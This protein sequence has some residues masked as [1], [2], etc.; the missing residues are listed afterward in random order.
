MANEYKL[1]LLL[2]DGTEVD[3]GVIVVPEGEK[4]DKGDTGATGPTGAHGKDGKSAYQYALEGGYSGTEQHFAAKLA[5][6][7][8]TPQMYGAVADGITDDTA[9]VQAALNAGG[10]IYFPAGRYKV[11]SQ[12]T[13]TKPCTISM[14]KQ[15]PSEYGNDYPNSSGDNWMG[16]RIETYSP[17]NG[18]VIGD[19]VN[20]DG[21]YI[22]AMAGFGANAPLHSYWSDNA[23]KGKGIVLQY[24]GTKGFKTYPSS[25]RLSHIRVDI[26]SAG[27]AYTVIPECLFDFK[28][29]AT[30]HYIIEDVILGQHG[31]RVCDF[32]FRADLA[33]SGEGWT[34]NAYIRN[35]CIDTCCDYG[36]F[37]NGGTGAMAG[38][39]FDGL[40]IQA[41]GYLT[42]AENP[43]NPQNRPGHRALIKLAGVETIA[44]YSAYLWDTSGTT[45]HPARYSDGGEIVVDGTAVEEEIKASLNRISCLG[46]SSHFDIIETYISKKLGSPDNLN[47]KNLE[48]SVSTDEVSGGNILELDDGTYK[49]SATIPA[50]VLSDEQINGAISAWMEENTVPK[51][52]IGR[53]KLDTSNYRVATS[54]LDSKLEDGEQTII[55]EAYLEAWGD[56]P[57]WIYK[58]G[59][60]WWTTHFIAAQKGDVFRFSRG[61]TLQQGYFMFCF[62]ANYKYLGWYNLASGS[63]PSGVDYRAPHVTIDNTAFVKL[64]FTGNVGMRWEGEDGGELCITINDSNISYEPYSAEY[65]AKMAGL[66]PS[67]TAADNGKTLKVVN[68]VWTPV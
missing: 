43:S 47:I 67:V 54:A 39:M 25:V 5:V 3:A 7:L 31:R 30:Y 29:S 8:V 38:W 56:G 17:T 50:A 2:S 23:V 53:N 42:P 40:T 35:M 10:N 65:K 45:E 68:G 14:Y 63:T 55:K 1:K 62:D 64:C 60:A 6:P 44:F 49:R 59:S 58:A 20:L 36:V 13:A 48:M 9:A 19:G 26:D 4:G 51:L 27:G 41:Y 15:Y 16:A 24:D 46:C 57:H 32:A 37:L 52:T 22:R 34:H 33:A 61:G 11:T 21:F 12:L 18:I 66:L 28:P